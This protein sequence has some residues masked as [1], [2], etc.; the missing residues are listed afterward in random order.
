V[1]RS[2]LGDQPALAW[3]VALGWCLALLGACLWQALGGPLPCMVGPM[4]AVALARALGLPVAE[5]PVGRALGQLVIGVGL[6]LNF[7][8]SVVAELVNR[9][10]LVMGVALLALW[11]G[12]LGAWAYQRW[13]GLSRP[14]AWLCALPGGASEMAVLATH[15]GVQ[16]SIVALTQGLRV[17][18]VVSLVPGL[19]LLWCGDLSGATAGPPWAMQALSMAFW[20]HRWSDAA[21][22]LASEGAT[23]AWLGLLLVG[24]ALARWGQGR[25]WPNVWLMAPLFLT[26]ALSAWPEVAVATWVRMPAPAMNLAQVLLG[27]ALGSKLDAQAWHQAPRLSLV[28]TAVVMGGVIGSAGLAAGLTWAWG[29]LTLTHYLALAPGG[30]AEM[31]LL[32]RQVQAHLPEVIAAHVVR[33]ALVLSLAPW[34]LARIR[35]SQPLRDLPP[36]GGD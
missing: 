18:L 25:G 32:A 30:M 33:L 17:A 35:R 16:P 9:W 7:T 1:S 27:I 11:P 12:A 24:A 36:S 5:W 13:A 19:L 20:A 4:L 26:A 21:G 14:A 28:A 15:H 23:A 8:P 3:R 22:T 34:W 6:G 31:A 29:G 10:P 2:E